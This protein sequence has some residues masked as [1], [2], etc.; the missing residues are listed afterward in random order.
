MRL[1]TAWL[2][3]LLPTVAVTGRAGAAAPVEPTG[4]IDLPRHMGR[5]HVAGVIPTRRERSNHDPMKTY[6]LDRDGN[7]CA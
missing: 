7:V 1:L 2:L 6:R 3:P 4:P 5:W